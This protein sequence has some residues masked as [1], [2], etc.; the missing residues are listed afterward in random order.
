MQLSGAKPLLAYGAN[1]YYFHLQQQE[2]GADV[3]LQTKRFYSGGPFTGKFDKVSL[4]L[5]EDCGVID[6]IRK[7]QTFCKKQVT[8]LE[9]APAE[10]KLNEAWKAL[11]RADIFVDFS[12]NFQAFDVN[13]Q[14]MER[15]KLGKGYYTLRLHLPGVYLGEHEKKPMARLQI[16]VSQAIFE[17]V[18]ENSVCMI[19]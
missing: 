9:G 3:F 4:H 14:P 7:I 17:P 1:K 11:K 2:G 13:K 19:E 15:E 8:C 6:A 16:K 12:D 10:W 18:E 5:S